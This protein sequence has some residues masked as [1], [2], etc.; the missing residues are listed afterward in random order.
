MR[1]GEHTTMTEPPSLPLS[2]STMIVSFPTI[3]LK[4]LTAY[5]RTRGTY[6]TYFPVTFYSIPQ[7]TVFNTVAGMAGW[8]ALSAQGRVPSLLLEALQLYRPDNIGQVRGGPDG[9]LHV[10][11]IRTSCME[12]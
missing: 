2:Q 12:P 7:F 10:H 9:R 6:I 1:S 8:I 3:K 4:V 5:C 11:Y